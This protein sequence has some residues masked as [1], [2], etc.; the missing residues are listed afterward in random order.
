LWWIISYPKTIK[1][2]PGILALTNHAWARAH[3]LNY[4][5]VALA[6][7]LIVGNAAR[8]PEWFDTALRTARLALIIA[9]RHILAGGLRL[10][11]VSAPESM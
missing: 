10:L 3:E 4:A 1:F 7:G 9:T 2:T 6:A 11:G 8:L 5:L